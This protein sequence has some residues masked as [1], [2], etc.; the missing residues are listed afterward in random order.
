MIAQFENKLVSSFLLYLDNQILKKGQAYSVN[1]VNF[2][3]VDD[4]FQVNGSNKYVFNCAFDQLVSDASIPTGGFSGISIE[5]SPILLGQSGFYGINYDHGQ[6][7][8][9]NLDYSGSGITTTG[10]IKD[11]NIY[12]NN[13]TEEELLFET[14]FELRAKATDQ[15]IS[16]SSALKTKNIAYP[17]IFIRLE[18]SKDEDFAFGGLDKM[19]SNFRCLVLAEDNFS[20]DACCSLLR[21]FR[22]TE[23]AVLNPIDLPYS[24]FGAITGSVYNYNEQVTNKTDNDK[25]FIWDVSVSKISFSN[26][27]IK[28]TN[29]QVCSAIVD[30]EVYTFRN[31]RM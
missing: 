31:P 3:I 14:K 25:A 5:G 15:V 23:F 29:P 1:T 4:V 11:F 12:L 2:N 18:S 16:S 8:F 9:D 20:L 24:S 26:S 6:I 10:C 19:V 28:L 13:F 21:G 22:K 30:F 7:Y 27:E 17:A